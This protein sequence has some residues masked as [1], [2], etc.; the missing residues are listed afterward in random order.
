[1]TRREA[2][3]FGAAVVVALSWGS[4]FAILSPASAPRAIATSLEDS[5]AAQGGCSAFKQG[6]AE[7]L[8]RRSSRATPHRRKI[9]IATT[10][11]TRCTNAATSLPRNATSV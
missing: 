2:T 3:I 5:I 4:T 7:D 8:R 1:M 6:A 10:M 11:L 9:G